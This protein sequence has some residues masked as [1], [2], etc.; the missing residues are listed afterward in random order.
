MTRYENRY[1]CRNCSSTVRPVAYRANC[2][3]CGGALQSTTSRYSGT[4]NP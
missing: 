1:E 3:D 4:T 2:P